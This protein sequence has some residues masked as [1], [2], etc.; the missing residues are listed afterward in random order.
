MIF[1]RFKRALQNDSMGNPGCISYGQSRS[2][3]V[4]SRGVVELQLGEALTLRLM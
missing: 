4:A 3:S 1:D 2:G